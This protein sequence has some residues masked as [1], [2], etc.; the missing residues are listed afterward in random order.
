[1][2]QNLWGKSSSVVPPSILAWLNFK[3]YN[4]KTVSRHLY[5]DAQYVLDTKQGMSVH[6]VFMR[7]NEERENNRPNPLMKRYQ[8][9]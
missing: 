5:F 7:L 6:T 8:R 3:K 2:N 4:T 9:S 1:M